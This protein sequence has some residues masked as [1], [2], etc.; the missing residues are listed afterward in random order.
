MVQGVN[1]RTIK[2]N[3]DSPLKAFDKSE[4]LLVNKIINTSKII[5][6]Y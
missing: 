6:G 4:E 2:R 1:K 5:K 3:E